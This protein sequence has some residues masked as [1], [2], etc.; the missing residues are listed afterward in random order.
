L[1]KILTRTLCSSFERQ[2]FV[3]PRSRIRRGFLENVLAETAHH[4][5]YC[6]FALDAAALEVEELVFAD[7]AGCRFVFGLGL[8]FATVM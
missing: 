1:F 8:A 6:V 3:L 2:Q 5:L 4:R 7:A